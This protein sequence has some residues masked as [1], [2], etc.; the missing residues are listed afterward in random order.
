MKSSVTYKQWFKSHFFN[1]NDLIILNSFSFGEKCLIFLEFFYRMMP[2]NLPVS[3]LFQTKKY[4]SIASLKKV[5][6]W[7]K[8]CPV[9]YV[10]I[11]KIR[12]SIN[13]CNFGRIWK[14][15]T[16]DGRNGYFF[17]LKLCS[18]IYLQIPLYCFENKKQ[19]QQQHPSPNTNT[20]SQTSGK[21]W[22][23]DGQNSDLIFQ[24]RYFSKPQ[25]WTF[26]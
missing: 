25:I 18:V 2:C 21:Y 24:L 19:H 3:E 13:F 22:V 7:V 23:K 4:F 14:S 26:K 12:S 1:Y 16:L 6:V 10:K 9:S 5:W 15:A 17:F 11:F 20:H 8:K